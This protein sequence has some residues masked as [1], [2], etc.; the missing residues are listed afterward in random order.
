[1]EAYDEKMEQDAKS[2]N[3]NNIDCGCQETKKYTP[4]RIYNPAGLS[5]LSYRI[6]THALFKS[7]MIKAIASEP[8]LEKLTTRSDNDLSIALLDSWATVADV[9]TFYQER[10]ANEGFL[11][12]STERMSVLELARSI[13]YELRPGVAASTFLAFTMEDSPGVAE[14]AMVDV[15]TKVQSIPAQGQMPQIFETIEKIEAR[16]EWNSIKPLMNKKQDLYESLQSGQVFFSGTSTRLKPGDG[17]LFVIAGE[18]V[19]F[20]IA[21]K[22]ELDTKL[23][24][25]R[26]AIS[27][28]IE[29]VSSLKGSG[30]GLENS[31][32][33][34]Q[35][36][37]G[38]SAEDAP[39]ID[40]ST[41]FSQSDLQM[42]LSK[43]WSESDLK[44]QAIIKGW[45]MDEIVK[46]VNS[47]KEELQGN[48]EQDYVCVFRVKCSVF[49]NNAPRWDSLPANQRYGEWVKK[50]NET[51]EFVQPVYTNNWDDETKVNINTD[52]AGNSYD[53]EQ[54]IGQIYL[55]NVYPG[56]LS[57]SW[58]VLQDSSGS[59]T[60]YRVSGIS[61][62]TMVDFALSAKV[63]GLTLERYLFT[64]NK[65][66]KD[67]SNQDRFK[68]F[69]KNKL[70]IEW[71]GTDTK[72][73]INNENTEITVSSTADPQ[74]LVSVKLE[75]EK[76]KATLTTSTHS[77][78]TLLV[79]SDDSGGGLLYVYEGVLQNFKLRRTN[80]Y[81]QSEKLT[82][83]EVSIKE[84]LPEK[85]IMPGGLVMDQIVLDHMVGGLSPNQPILITGNLEDQPG[86]VKN[87]ITLLSDIVHFENNTRL[88]T[89]ILSKALTYK[90]KRDSVIINANIARATHG[91]TR[92]EVIGSGNP[93]LRFQRLLLKQ[94]PLTFVSSST[95][96]GIKSTL[97]I[98]IDGNLWEESHSLYDLTYSDNAYIYRISDDG[99]TRIIFG[100]G[101]KGKLPPS[102][103]ENIKAQYRVGIGSSGMLKE[104]QLSL[105]MT[106]PL[107][108]RSVT[109]PLKSSGAADPENIDD[110]RQNAPRTVLTLDRI[111]SLE[112]FKNFAQGFAGIGKAKSSS[113]WLDGSNIVLLT[114]VDTSGEKIDYV[115]DL[116]INLVNAIESFKDPI[117]QFRVES[118]N[119]KLFNVEA[120][121]LV[122]NDSK[123]EN[124][125]PNVEAA[126]KN[127]FSFKMRDFG[128]AVTIAEVISTIQGVEGVIAVDIDALY[129]YDPATDI[130][131]QQG[132]NKIIYAK[133]I[134]TNNRLMTVVAVPSL[135][136]INPDGIKLTEMSKL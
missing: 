41:S 97:E 121:V 129:E 46:T 60:A 51:I 104:G 87:E 131:S 72:F 11:R 12:T 71:A 65:I 75:N 86:L 53:T 99:Q 125:K 123:F 50:Q 135:L 19:A 17:L 83:S 84:P 61:E 105:L 111:V 23:Q 76:T 62:K 63:T 77:R 30:V 31:S 88:T 80:V 124:I 115:A 64:W 132:Y 43:P 15:G 21:N 56:I 55:D 1:M 40:S 90:F 67:T 20:R 81:A 57:Q 127:V 93:S 68:D 100:D 49:G 2:D 69:L 106:R 120:K 42:I 108:V 25:T 37:S 13:G 107:G 96:S 36:A 24:Q 85:R 70:G 102:G 39:Q 66:L 94:K 134:P 78:F 33:K 3:D 128:Q 133:G 9:L 73:S 35:K 47:K 58:V 113:I 26:V 44:A 59:S 7:S 6:G 54:N 116:Y 117:I 45:S 32:S 79:K 122:S 5:Y 92:Q 14:K 82:L 112:D 110:A 34:I 18:P 16:H 89:L 8:A 48:D 74:K 4:V 10:I 91:E 118:F 103:L 109:N 130:T 22:V 29:A 101:V 52:S 126:L 114:V 119:P 28:G 136:V 27:K 95:E 38:E 98:R